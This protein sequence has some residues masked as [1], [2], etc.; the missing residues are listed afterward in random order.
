MFELQTI[1]TAVQIITAVVT[2]ASI[3]AAAT[4]TGRDDMYVSKAKSY[5]RQARKVI[6]VL[7]FNVKNA[8]N[9]ED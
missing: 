3:I 2:A 7:G 9:L 1:E 6:N 5:W 4:P 8:R